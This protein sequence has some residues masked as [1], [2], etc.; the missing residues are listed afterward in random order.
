M[1]TNRRQFLS[2]ALTGGVGAAA[3]QYDG[4]GASRHFGAGGIAGARRVTGDR[5]YDSTGH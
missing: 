2:T 4:A 3:L 1:K 5:Q